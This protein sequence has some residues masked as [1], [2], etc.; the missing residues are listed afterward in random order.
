MNYKIYLYII[1]GF[2]TMFAL[3]G[4]NF[5]NLFHQSKAIEAKIFVMILG[6][7]ITYLV[8]NFIYDFI[9]IMSQIWKIKFY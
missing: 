2:T 9:S 4:I 5:N 3:S 6:L 1:I 7:S 8:T